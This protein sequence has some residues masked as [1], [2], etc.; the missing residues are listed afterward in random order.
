VRVVRAYIGAESEELLRDGHR[1]RLAPVAR[2]R[3][4]GETE[5][6]DAG[7]VD[8]ASLLVQQRDDAADDVLGHPAVD[9]V[10]E[11]DEAETVPEL[12]LDPPREV[13]GIDREAVAA[14]PRPRCEPHEAVR[15]GGGC[16]DR[17]PDVD[18][19]LG[20]TPETTFGVFTN[21][22]TVLPG[23]IRAGE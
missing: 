9:L 21:V 16:V 14:D 12:P 23:S 5:Q 6:Q 22:Q 10:R 17:R 4:V 7:A 19:E 8:G 11:L 18:T 3:L 2:S 13:R 20:P 15:L 1:R